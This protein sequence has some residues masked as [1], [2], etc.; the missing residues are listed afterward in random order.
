QH[1]RSSLPV[2]RYKSNNSNADE[3]FR[4]H[5]WSFGTTSLEHR[6]LMAQGDV[7]NLQCSLATKAGEKGTERYQ[8]NVQHAARSLS[9]TRRK[10]NNSHA[11]EVFRKHTSLSDPL[12]ADRTILGSTHARLNFLRSVPDYLGDAFFQKAS[13]RRVQSNGPG[14]VPVGFD[15]MSLLQPDQSSISISLGRVSTL[16]CLIEI[17]DGTLHISFSYFHNPAIVV[18]HGVSTVTPEYLIEICQRAIQIASV[19]P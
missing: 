4:N 6:Y 5:N 2:A 3:V 16:Y 11:D 10:S 1:G 7:F 17:G 14:K 15:S 18:R 13:D 8:D 9:T 19:E 12:P